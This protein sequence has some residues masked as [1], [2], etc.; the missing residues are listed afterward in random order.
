[1]VELLERR[2]KEL[3]REINNCVNDKKRNDF[4]KLL[5]M[6]VKILNSIKGSNWDLKSLR[7]FQ[8]L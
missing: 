6:N 2:I 3:K 1:M 8:T 7:V 4:K 5:D